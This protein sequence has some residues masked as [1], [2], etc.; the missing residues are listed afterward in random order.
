MRKWLSATSAVTSL[1]PMPR[2]DAEVVLLQRA[3]KGLLP[4]RAAILRRVHEW[5]TVDFVPLVGGYDVH[6]PAEYTALDALT[7]HTESTEHRRVL[8]PD[9]FFVEFSPEFRLAGLSKIEADWATSTFTKVVTSFGNYYVT[10]THAIGVDFDAAALRSLRPAGV[11]V[12]PTATRRRPGPPDTFDWVAAKSMM[13]KKAAAT[14]GLPNTD[15]KRIDVIL[16]WF[17]KTFDEE[18]SR[19]RVTQ[20]LREWKMTRRSE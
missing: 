19:A 1:G 6:H 15:A 16:E 2:A 4:A 5:K 8:L 14:E 20:K 3:V 9:D 13:E 12:S 17:S 18:P 11:A 7:P 10:T